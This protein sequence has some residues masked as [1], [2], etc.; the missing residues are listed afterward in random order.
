MRL[1]RLS[2][3]HS[4]CQLSS[5]NAIMLSISLSI[6]LFEE[7]SHGSDPIKA[8]EARGLYQ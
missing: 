1:Q 2:D 7:I 5:V 8:I 3:M 6:T 4:A